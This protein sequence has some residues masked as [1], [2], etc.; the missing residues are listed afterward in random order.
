MSLII[1]GLSKKYDAQIAVADLSFTID[2]GSVVGFL[3]PNGAG[4]STTLKMIAGYLKP[5]AGEVIL[6]DI[7]N[8]K[9]PIPFKK[10][11]GYLPESNPLYEEMYVKEYFSFLASIHNI[12]NPAERIE[13]LI[14]LTG[15]QSMQHKKI[16]ELSKGYKQRVGIAA[17]I[18]HKPALVLLD[19]PTSGLDPNQLVEIRN[20]I[21]RISKDAIVLFSTHILQ[22]VSAICSSVLVLHKAKLVANTLINDLLKPTQPAVR[23]VFEEDIEPYLADS[24]FNALDFEKQD[25]HVLVIK[26][27]DINK[28]KKEVLNFALAKGL[29]IQALQT[30]EASLE[31]IFKLLTH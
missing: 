19:E 5:D 25:K 20:L 9:D 10:L 17:A 2:K 30:Q 15:L 11:V 22:E 13:E 26:S 1:K 21:V 14:E 16:A 24:F 29:N 8:Q 7:S 12:N 23:V 3:G 28:L 18:I 4:K 31:E 6:N 27:K